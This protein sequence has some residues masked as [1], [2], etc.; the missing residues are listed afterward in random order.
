MLQIF[1]VLSIV[2]GLSNGV[3]IIVVK[4][5]LNCLALLQVLL[6]L[7]MVMLVMVHVH[8]CVLM[9]T[10]RV[11]IVA[12]SPQLW[13]K[14]WRLQYINMYFTVACFLLILL[15]SN[16][17][18]NDTARIN[19]LS[20]IMMM[21]RLLCVLSFVLGIRKIDRLRHYLG[22]IRRRSCSIVNGIVSHN[23]S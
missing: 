15:E 3:E 2:L 18:S 5:W 7:I 17:S 19:Q 21:S 6:I 9:M 22:L 10:V 4:R 20:C 11:L 23:R 1:L 12:W 13:I 16:P 14:S 8:M